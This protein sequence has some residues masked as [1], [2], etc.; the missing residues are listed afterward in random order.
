MCMYVIV[1]VYMCI[2][3]CIYVYM[4]VCLCVCL[5]VC[6]CLCVYI[7]TVHKN[8]ADHCFLFNSIGANSSVTVMPINLSGAIFYVYLWLYGH[9]VKDHSD[10]ERGNPLPPL[11][12][13]F[14]MHHPTDRHLLVHQLWST[15]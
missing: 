2:Y 13:M 9:M 11:H 6:M 15:G 3:M 1:C 7:S 10:S 14:Y 12:G 4:C 8:N 5:C